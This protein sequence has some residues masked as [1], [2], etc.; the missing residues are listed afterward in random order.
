MRKDKYISDSQVVKRANAAVRIELDKKK[1]LDIPVAIFDR[2]TQVI[3]QKNSDG[4][5]VAIGG[6]IRKGR[7]SERVSKET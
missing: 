7:Y 6:R 1:A 5:K 4:T 3:Y 2:K